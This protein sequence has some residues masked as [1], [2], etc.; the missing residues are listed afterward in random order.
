[1]HAVRAGRASRAE[2]PRRGCAPWLRAE[3]VRSNPSLARTHPSRTH[4]GSCARNFQ[5]RHRRFPSRPPQFDT[6]LWLKGLR[7]SHQAEDAEAVNLILRLPVA[8]H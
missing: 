1:M 6:S 7:D 8:A 5:R 3:A 4:R 2:A